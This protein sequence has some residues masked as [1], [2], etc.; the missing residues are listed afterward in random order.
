MSKE[1]TYEQ[2]SKLLAVS[3]SG[4]YDAVTRGR[5]HPIRKPGFRINFL[6]EDEVIRYGRLDKRSFTVPSEDQ[7]RLQRPLPV[8]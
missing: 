2:A 3:L 5:L 1:I 6:D 8:R 7:G 4:V